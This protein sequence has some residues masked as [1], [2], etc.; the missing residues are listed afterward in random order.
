MTFDELLVQNPALRRLRLLNAETLRSMFGRQRG[1]CTWCGKPVGK[2]RQTWCSDACTKDF[3]HRCSPGHAALFVQKRD[4]DICR[5]CGVNVKQ[6]KKDFEA[7]WAIRSKSLAEV[8]VTHGSV[9]TAERE[10][11]MKEFGFARGRWHEIDHEIPVVEGGGLCHPD[12][13]RLLCG[14]CHAAETAELAGRRS[15]KTKRIKKVGK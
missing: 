9:W 12:R 13:L 6:Q 10:K 15:K 1:E 2:G 14:K 3:L 11:M 7:A 5:L 8:G 4:K